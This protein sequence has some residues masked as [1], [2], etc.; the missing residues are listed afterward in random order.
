MRLMLFCR[1]DGIEKHTVVELPV[2]VKVQGVEYAAHVRS[3][4]VLADMLDV[5]FQRYEEEETAA[6][7]LQTHVNDAVGMLQAASVRGK[8]RC[9]DG[10]VVVALEA[11]A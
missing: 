2:L 6:H 5:V 8:L 11:V 7:M 1:A 3:L 4:A 10:G 9:G